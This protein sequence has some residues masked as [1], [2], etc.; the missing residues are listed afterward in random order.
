MLDGSAPKGLRTPDMTSRA[1]DIFSSNLRRLMRDKG[2]ETA[3]GVERAAT[4]KGLGVG[5]T[6]IGRYAAGEGNPTLEHLETLSEV[7]GLSPW[8]LL[9]PSLGRD[10]AGPTVAEQ[11]DALARVLLRLPPQDRQE[12][13]ECF[14]R[15]AMAPENPAARERLEKLFA[16][17]DEVAPMSRRA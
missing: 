12:V 5:R 4:A 11:L 10:G 3:L 7:F 13:A 2:P 14:H 1:L 15:M 16:L 9:H 8:R 17:Q 6:S